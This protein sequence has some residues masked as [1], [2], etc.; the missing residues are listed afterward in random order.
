MRANVQRTKIAEMENLS[1]QLNILRVLLRVAKEIRI[2]D[3]KKY[4][5]LQMIIDE[6]GRQIGGWIKSVKKS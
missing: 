5:N 2:I 6:I 4:V 1:R 3:N